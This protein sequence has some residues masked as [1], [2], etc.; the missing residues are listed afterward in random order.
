MRLGAVA[1]VLALTA[2]ASF[3]WGPA[4]SQFRAVSIRD[5]CPPS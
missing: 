5:L 3:S 4:P 2:G 1:L